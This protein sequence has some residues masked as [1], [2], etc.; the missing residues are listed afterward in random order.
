VGIKMKSMW[1]NK[2]TIATH[3]SSSSTQDKGK[4]TGNKQKDWKKK[5]NE[6][7]SYGSYGVQPDRK[8]DPDRDGASGGGHKTHPS[9][10]RG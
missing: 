9:R 5:Q 6:K 10:R 4:A 3:P 8:E 2:F 1:R 7:P